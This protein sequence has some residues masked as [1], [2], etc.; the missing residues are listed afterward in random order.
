MSVELKNDSSEMQISG[1]LPSGI[2]ARSV[3]GF[4]GYIVKC[5]H[6]VSQARHY[7]G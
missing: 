3:E 1:N 7:Y 6:G 2:S 5:T 4:M